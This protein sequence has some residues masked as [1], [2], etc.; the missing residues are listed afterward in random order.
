MQDKVLD[1]LHKVEL[2]LGRLG[3][4]GSVVGEVMPVLEFEA[5]SLLKEPLAEERLSN[6][7]RFL[8]H[9]LGVIGNQF[10]DRRK[11]DGS[12]NAVLWR[13]RANFQKGRIESVLPDSEL[14]RAL[15]FLIDKSFEL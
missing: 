14:S 6:Y 5:F 7:F 9:K 11:K 8:N 10:V 1:E 13:H 12:D 2:E 4:R 15:K 3:F